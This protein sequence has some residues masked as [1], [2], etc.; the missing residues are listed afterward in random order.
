MGQTNNTNINIQEIEVGDIMSEE[1][2]Y[3]VDSKTSNGV[4]FTHLES[5][6]KVTLDNNYVSDLLKTA[7]Q[8]HQETEVGREDKYWTQKQI[9]DAIAKGEL[10]S[11]TK[12]R[13]GDV[14]LKG[15]RTIWE[16][17]TGGQVFTVCFQ[18][19]G[20][21]LSTKAYNEKINTTAQEAA[22][23]I[24]NA[25]SGKRSVSQT[26]IEII[27][28]ILKNPVLPYETG[29]FRELRGF[30][31]EFSSRDGKY[32]CIDMD[33][34]GSYESKIRPVNI[35]TIVWLVYD[36]VKYTVK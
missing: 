34:Q 7:D 35:N 22:D 15:I 18:K 6:K 10:K 14:R 1:S 31:I 26:A 13:P 9:D 24:L 29:E 4:V 8:Y 11:D 3:I 23:K 32:N 17:I 27:Q 12:L 25:K 2:R 36:G 20:K 28:D 16:D 30:K 5:G 19:Q 21:E 33:I